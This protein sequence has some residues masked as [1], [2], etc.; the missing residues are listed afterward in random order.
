[1]HDILNT[2]PHIVHYLY[3]YYYTYLHLQYSTY[4]I[5]KTPTIQIHLLYFYNT[6]STHTDSA[7]IHLTF[8][9]NMHILYTYTFS[10][11]I[12]L[13]HIHCISSCS[14]PNIQITYKK[15]TQLKCRLDHLISTTLPPASFIFFIAAVLMLSL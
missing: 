6:H 7:Y 11:T 9:I 2:I 8:T 14:A 5:N 4:C 13:H 1:M 15:H 3:I 10:H 12:H